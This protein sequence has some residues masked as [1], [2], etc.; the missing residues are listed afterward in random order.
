MGEKINIYLSGIDM[1]KM[2]FSP[3]TLEKMFKFENQHIP[4]YISLPSWPCTI[5][6]PGTAAPDTEIR[7]GPTAVVVLSRSCSC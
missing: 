7:C 2:L 5:A 6:G 3:S 4:N 1:N